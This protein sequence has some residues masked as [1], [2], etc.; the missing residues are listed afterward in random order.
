MSLL[1]DLSEPLVHY[2]ALCIAERDRLL[3]RDPFYRA[4]CGRHVVCPGDAHLFTRV[5]EALPRGTLLSPGLLS[6]GVPSAILNHSRTEFIIIP[7]HILPHPH[8]MLSH[9]ADGFSSSKLSSPPAAALANSDVF[10]IV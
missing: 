3:T 5:C 7:K 6:L 2:C 4:P 1:Q 9:S 10:Y 8:P